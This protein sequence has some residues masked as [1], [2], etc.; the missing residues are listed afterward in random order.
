[1]IRFVIRLSLVAGLAFMAP[2]ILA[3]LSQ[4]SMDSMNA[5]L[6]SAAF[7]SAGF[8]RAL[9]P[10]AESIGVLL[11]PEV[12]SG[13]VYE[14]LRREEALSGPFGRGR[15]FS[16]NMTLLNIRIAEEGTFVWKMFYIAARYCVE[17]ER[18][19]ALGIW[20]VSAVLVSLSCVCLY[21]KFLL[22]ARLFSDINMKFSMLVLAL[23]SSAALA[24]RF[25]VRLAL[26][27]FSSLEY[28]TVPMF[29]AVVSV[30]ILKRLDSEYA[31]LNRLLPTL[32]L[33]LLALVV[34]YGWDYALITASGPAL[35]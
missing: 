34:A 11:R 9:G 18:K 6:Q 30:L 29:F 21:S 1:M 31:V 10:D 33:P 24:S 15:S 3:K 35:R 32:L 12:G 17:H 5:K 4:K 27:P 16:D 7:N 2:A 25:V 14:R 13:G 19:V 26:V 8:Q 22:A 20:L 23:A 28:F